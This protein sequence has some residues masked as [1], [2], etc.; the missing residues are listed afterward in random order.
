MEL[1]LL[2]HGIA[3]DRRPGRPDDKRALTDEGRKKL[4]QVLDRARAAG[5]APSLILTSPYV[6]AVQ[7][8]Q[9]AAE[10]LGYQS[11]LVH[12]GALVPGSRPEA[13]WLEIRDHRDEQAVLLAGHEPLLSEL[14]AYLLGVP[15][16]AIDFKKGALLRLDV[17]TDARQ[18]RGTLQW[19]LTPKLAAGS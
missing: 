12:T 19:L 11:T 6:R 15:G 1:Y 7:T 17:D 4:R 13:A 5:V 18:P 2:R 8:A 10:V 14:A 9:M 3:D 16:L